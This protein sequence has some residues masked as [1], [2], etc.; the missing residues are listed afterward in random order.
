[1][2]FKIRFLLIHIA[3]TPVIVGDSEENEV[4]VNI[5]SVST[6][7]EANR[8]VTNELNYNSCDTE[9]GVDYL[10]ESSTDDL[11]PLQVMSEDNSVPSNHPRI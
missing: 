11:L 8:S 6:Q 2:T 10:E 9:L 7:N 4:S 1:M 5:S 3:E